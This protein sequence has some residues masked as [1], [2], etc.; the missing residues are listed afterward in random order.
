MI[1]TILKWM[2]RI[3]TGINRKVQNRPVYPEDV[4]KL[5]NRYKK[6]YSYSEVIDSGYMTC[7]EETMKKLVSLIPIRFHEY[8]G[9]V[10]D[11]DNFAREF[12]ALTKKLFLN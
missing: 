6:E 7:N 5:M 9:D 1:Q 2:K 10:Y 8:N 3:W 4:V 12:W 11:C